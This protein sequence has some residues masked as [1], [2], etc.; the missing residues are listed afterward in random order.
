MLYVLARFGVR[1]RADMKLET[2]ALLELLELVAPEVVR[3]L[4]LAGENDPEQL[5]LLRFDSGEHP[6]F[7]EHRAGEILG[8]I[9]DEQQGFAFGVELDHVLLEHVQQLD[10]LLAERLEAEFD[11]DGLQQLGRRQLSLID[12]REDNVLGQLFE[13]TLDQRRLARTD[14]AR[15][16]DEAVRKPDRRLHIGFRACCLLANRNCGSGVR[17]N[18]CSSSWKS[19]QYIYQ[20][21][22]ATD[23][24]LAQK[25]RGYEDR[26]HRLCAAERGFELPEL[27]N[28]CLSVAC[29]NRAVPDLALWSRL[30]A[31][32]VKM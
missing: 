22:A 12:V 10:L 14:L 21:F 6:N 27:R 24:S 15:D 31:V 25:G 19:S 9:D 5:F 26:R 17:R 28:R 7:L 4:R 2:D 18:G 32:I 23:K 3:E 16:D 20:I 13:K 29:E 1:Q 30:L 8:F 11:E